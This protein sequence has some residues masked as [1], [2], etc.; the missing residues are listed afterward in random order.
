MVMQEKSKSLCLGE[1]KERKITFE[2]GYE[3]NEYVLVR[4]KITKREE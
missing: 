4:W 2:K 3:I 1:L